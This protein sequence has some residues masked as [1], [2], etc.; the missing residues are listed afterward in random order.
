MIDSKHILCLLE[1]NFVHL[2]WKVYKIGQK[3]VQYLVW[4]ADQA[5]NVIDSDV[6]KDYVLRFSGHCGEL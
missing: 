1:P 6:S 3:S 2:D 4:K 5:H